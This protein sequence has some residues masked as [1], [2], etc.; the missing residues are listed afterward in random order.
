MI[1]RAGLGPLA[2]DFYTKGGKTRSATLNGLAEGQRT[3]TL[4][5][6]T[7][8]VERRAEPRFGVMLPALLDQHPVTVT[9]I[10][11]SGVGTGDGNMEMMIDSELGPAKGQRASLRL[12]DDDNEFGEDSIQI[13]IVRVSS[14]RGT[15][16]ARYVD[17]TDDQAGLLRKIVERRARG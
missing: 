13:E 1:R 12:L 11:M 10:S 7:V 3:M 16:G 17:L 8:A 4:A 9:D 2:K 15:L 5:S 6:N 14:R